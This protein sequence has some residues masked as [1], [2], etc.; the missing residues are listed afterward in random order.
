[1]GS[2]SAWLR[3]SAARKSAFASSVGDD[4]DLTGTSEQI[5]ANLA[6][7]QFLCESDVDITGA[8]N[9]VRSRYGGR[10]IRQCRDCPG[11]ANLVNPGY[12]NF[13]GGHKQIGIHRAIPTRRGDQRDVFHAGKACGDS[14]HE[15]GRNER[16]LSSL[17]SRNV[18]A[19]RCNRHY[20]LSQE[21]PIRPGDKIGTPQLMAMKGVDIRNSRLQNSKEVGV[22]FF[23]C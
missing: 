21:G 1:M 15:D 7:H 22:D 11:T 19:G 13:P 6:C 17:T 9:D 8:D 18:K 23:V 20:H 2:C 5:D 16:G 14:I 3:R 10:S 4:E 12:S